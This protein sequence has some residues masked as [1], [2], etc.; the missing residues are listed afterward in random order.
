MILAMKSAKIQARRYRDKKRPRHKWVL[1]LRAYSKG[2]LFF[3]TR[4]EAEQEQD[5]QREL[6]ERQGKAALELKDRDL[7]EFIEA[8]ERL[9]S[10]GVTIRQATDF[11][12][13]HLEKIRRCNVTIAQLTEEMIEAKKRDGRAE[14]YLES[15]RG[16]LGRFCKT[17][18]HRPV[19]A[20]TVEEL[21]S[22]LRNLAYS[23][24]SR[25]NF[26][27]NIGVLFGYA[28]QRRM[29]TENPIEFTARPKLIDKPPGILTP[30]ETR[31]LLEAAGRIEPE[32]VPMLAIGA[33]AGLRD[34]EI[35]RL[36]WSEVKLD[37]GHIEIRAA[38][39]KS[40]R[41]RLVP[42]QP[43]LADWLRPYAGRAGYVVPDG[44]RGMVG[45]ARKAANIADWPHNALRHSFASY[46]LAD[47]QDAPRTALELGHTSPQLVFQ[48]YREVVTPEDAARYWDVR[49]TPQAA[50]VVSFAS[51]ASI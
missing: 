27:Q 15:L 33:F 36:D 6:L 25:A 19:A 13:N 50:N 22:W 21:D 10:Y 32:V 48:H 43:N 1:D 12:I 9:Q 20:V 29:I 39:A 17:F 7:A 47:S 31:A 30:D 28:K 3:T 41:R 8:R 34:S 42:I 38:K 45:R 24:K 40:A 4:K 23:P 16:Y 2:R 51:E 49:P 18:G 44:Y 14:K 35:H 11:A 46:R 26:R 37:R 5:R